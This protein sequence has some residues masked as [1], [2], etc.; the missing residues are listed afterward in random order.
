M[1][2][3]D[4]Q[5]KFYE[6]TLKVTKKEIS[7]LEAQ[8]QEELAKVKERLA[9]FRTLRGRARDMY[10]AACRA[11]V[12]RTTSRGR[13]S[14]PP[15]RGAPPR[16]TLEMRTPRPLFGRPG[17]SRFRRVSPPRIGRLPSRLGR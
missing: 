10:A 3:N 12:S 13:E 14:N 17:R 11:S 7:D 2:L 4:D 15:G 5:R 16:R 6:N 1:S 8:I 9:G